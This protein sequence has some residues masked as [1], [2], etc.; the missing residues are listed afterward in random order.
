M[1][2][3]TPKATRLRRVLALGLCVL[4]LTAASADAPR[5]VVSINLCTDQLLLQLADPAQIASIS[6]LAR[7]PDS[8]FMAAEAQGYPVNHARIEEVLSQHPDLVMG[9]DYTD[10]RL[11]RLL[12]GLGIPAARIPMAETLEGIRV[13]IRETA[14]LLGRQPQGE[15][16]I[17][18][19]QAA[20]DRVADQASDG[21]P[22]KALF[23]QPRGYTSGLNTLQDEALRAAGWRNL[24][25]EL[26]ISGYAPLD[27]ERLVM[28]APDQLFTSP[29]SLGSRSRAQDLLE[30][31]A[32]RRM[33]GGRPLTEIPYKYW[34]CGGPMI[35]DAIQLLAQA[36]AH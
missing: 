30:H 35:V 14:A 31:P 27:L 11:Y 8:S 7:D 12:D 19:M 28:A 34:I 20:L 25:S 32:L 5:R 23:I 21:S 16:L 36:H 9:A 4:S 3:A 26:G 33:L 24:A 2:D 13:N 15:R 1:L 10:P 29:L 17:E 6:Y 18:E 22:T